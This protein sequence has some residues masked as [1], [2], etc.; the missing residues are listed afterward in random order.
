MKKIVRLRNSANSSTLFQFEKPTKSLLNKSFFAKFKVNIKRN[1]RR[2][3][4]DILHKIGISNRELPFTVVLSGASRDT[5][6]QTIIDLAIAQTTIYL[7]T[8]GIND[9]LNSKYDFI[10]DFKPEINEKDKEVILKFTLIE[11]VN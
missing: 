7:D 8:E 11:N 9:E 6:A 5:N 10:G 3:A 2:G 1:P 4:K